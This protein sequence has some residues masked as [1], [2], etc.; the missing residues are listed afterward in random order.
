MALREGAMTYRCP[1]CQDTSY[2]W[3]GSGEGDDP[4]EEIPCPVCGPNA[5]EEPEWEEWDDDG[6]C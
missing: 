5:T 3:Q 1:R 6:C 2:V 4:R